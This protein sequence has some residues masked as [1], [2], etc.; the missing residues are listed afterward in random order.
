M[1]SVGTQIEE[2]FYSRVIEYRKA[3]SSDPVVGNIYDPPSV[4]FSHQ[5]AGDYEWQELEPA[6]EKL[7]ARTK[8]FEVRAVGLVLFGGTL[9]VGL[10]VDERLAEFHARV[11][12]TVA[13]FAK[14]GVTEYEPAI[15]V[16]HVTIKRCGNDPEA[17]GEAVRKLA[18]EKFD[19]SLPVTNIAALHDPTP[20]GHYLRGRFELAG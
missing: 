12:E 17:I 11:W 5:V 4:H 16:P 18:S 9:V 8:P 15:W 13:P 10:R 7:A 6:L 14:E 20:N 1:S 19:W 2:P 3:L